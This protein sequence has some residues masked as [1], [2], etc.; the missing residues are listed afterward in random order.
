MELN[1]GGTQTVLVS[2]TGTVSIV[3]QLAT[4]V[5]G[6]RLVINP[7]GA[8]QPEIRFLPGTGTNPARMYVDGSM[9]AGEATIVTVSGADGTNTAQC[10]VVHAATDYRV[11]IINPTTGLAGGGYLFAKPAELEVGYNDS[12]A[13]LNRFKFS[14]A[15]TQFAEKWSFSGGEAGLL[16]RSVSLSGGSSYTVNWTFTMVTVPRVVFT[17]DNPLPDRLAFHMR[18]PTTASFSFRSSESSLSTPT[19]FT[20]QLNMWAWRM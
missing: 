2:S 19:Q 10:Q 1:A 14:A 6:N 7:A 9:Y 4:G 3:G 17:A 12:S 13:N 18:N 8:T 5:T 15:S 11:H 20:V 16:M